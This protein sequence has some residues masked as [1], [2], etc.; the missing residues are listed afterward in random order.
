MI[1]LLENISSKFRYLQ[2][3]TSHFQGFL[4]F[5]LNLEFSSQFLE[6]VFKQNNKD[7]FHILKDIFTNFLE[8][9]E[10]EE[11]HKK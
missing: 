3:L 4:K 10:E 1:N 5:L 7:T 8:E 9:E 11:V 6:P 2:S